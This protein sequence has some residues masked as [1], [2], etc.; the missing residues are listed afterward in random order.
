MKKFKIYLDNCCFNRPFDNL[1]QD[2]VRFECEAVLSIL[3]NCEDG[4]WDIFR[5][6]VLDDEIDKIPNLVNKIKVLMLYSSASINVEIS[7]MIIRRAKEFQSTANIKPFDALHLASA[8]QGG[9]D[10]LLTTDRKFLTNAAKSDAKVRVS[11]PAIW[12]TEVMY[13]D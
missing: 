3:K 12:I 7:D 11:N 10:I 5:S 9:A 13:N 8:E 4:I 6:D 1:S 2:K